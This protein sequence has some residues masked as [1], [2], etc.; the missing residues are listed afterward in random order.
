SSTYQKDL[1]LIR[2][3]ASHDSKLGPD[4]VAIPTYFDASIGQRIVL[5]ED[6]EQ[7]FKDAVYITSNEGTV[8]LLEDKDGHVL[9]PKRILHKPGVVLE[10]VMESAPVGTSSPSVTSVNSYDFLD[11]FLGNHSI[12]QDSN[13]HQ[14]VSDC[15]RLYG[16][17]LEAIMSGQARQAANIRDNLTEIFASWDS[18]AL[19]QENLLGQMQRLRQAIQESQR[20]DGTQIHPEILSEMQQQV[21]QAQQESIDRLVIMRSH[22]LSVLNRTFEM[23]EYP[24]FIVLPMVGSQEDGQR[25]QFRLHFLCEYTASAESSSIGLSHELHLA[26]HQG[27]NLRQ[28]DQFLKTYGTYVLSTLGVMKS[29]S[30]RLGKSAPS[31]GQTELTGGLNEPHAGQDPITSYIDTLVDEAINFI[32]EYQEETSRKFDNA[33][34][35]ETEAETFDFSHSADMRQL[36]R[37]LYIPSSDRALGDLYRTF[38]ND[39][40]SKW[41][42]KDHYYENIMTPTPIESHFSLTSNTSTFSSGRTSV[43]EMR[44]LVPDTTVLQASGQPPNQ[45]QQQPAQIYPTLTDGQTSMKGADAMTSMAPAGALS[46]PR[47]HSGAES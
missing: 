13:V 18:E 9:M 15:Y 11:K 34:G 10:V 3:R 46:I 7:V 2:V 22:I 8:P 36:E 38:D 16:S 21:L 41:V 24:L 44:D 20:L 30:R 4:A 1:Q 29:Q 42:C 27:Y 39:G 5:M 40:Y 12:D 25:R 35:D 47:R 14:S 28:L 45:L 37:Q 31:P 17:Q 26:K 33:S 32:E 19:K 23:H 43:L 6:I